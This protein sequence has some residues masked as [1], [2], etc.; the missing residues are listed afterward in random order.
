[1]NF[2][3]GSNGIKTDFHKFFGLYVNSE[4]AVLGWQW[5]KLIIYSTKDVASFTF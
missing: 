2:M 1:M 5:I 4:N 3:E